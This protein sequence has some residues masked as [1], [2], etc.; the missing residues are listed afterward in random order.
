M[1]VGPSLA[2]LV[3]GLAGAEQRLRRNA[4][5]I[6]TFSADEVAL[7]Q[8]DAQTALGERSHGWKIG[9]I[10]AIPIRHLRPIANAYGFFTAMD[11]AR[12]FLRRQGIDRPKEDV[13]RTVQPISAR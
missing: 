13:L 11:E 10:D 1:R 7:D 8:C 12:A 2:R 5:P 9:I 4:R 6:R 3:H